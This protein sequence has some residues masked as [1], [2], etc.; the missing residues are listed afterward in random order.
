MHSKSFHLICTPNRCLDICTKISRELKAESQSDLF[1]TPVLIWEPVPGAISPTAFS[2]CLTA[3]NHVDIFSP[4]AKEAADFFG[5]PEPESKQQIRKVALQFLVHMVHK[6]IIDVDGANTSKEQPVNGISKASSQLASSG[7]SS[8]SSLASL[9]K[10]RSLSSYQQV[11]G[12]GQ[13]GLSSSPYPR[14]VVVRCGAKGCAVYSQTKFPTSVQQT[15]TVIP[16]FFDVTASS[17]EKKPTTLRFY[18]AWFPAYHGDPSDA[19]YKVEDPTGG[20]NTFLGGFAAGYLNDNR[21]RGKIGNLAKAAIYGNIAAGL[22]IEQ[23]GFPQ[24]ERDTESWNGS[25]VEQRLD[26]YLAKHGFNHE[27]LH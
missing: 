19:G 24:L 9:E 23:V 12:C 15:E 1:E 25:S 2:E 22:A 4:N 6:R 7:C 13:N 20:G 14:A 5:L 26:Q 21:G 17:N 3:L 10:D 18:E 27:I 11:G 8:H 16:V